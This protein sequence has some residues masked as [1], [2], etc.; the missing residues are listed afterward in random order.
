MSIRRIIFFFIFSIPGLTQ[1][2]SAQPFSQFR[3][4]I[5][6]SMF[7]P[8]LKDS[9]RLE[10]FFPREAELAP[11]I[12]YPVVFLFDRQNRSNYIYN[13]QTIDYLTHFGNMPAA[14][15]VGVEFPPLVRTKWT[16][17]ASAK[18][19]ADTLLTFL[20]GPFREQL[21]KECKLA[22]YN[23]LIGHSRTAM[24]A[25]YALPAF[26]GKI[27]AVIAASNSFFDFDTPSQQQLFE[28]YIEEKKL[29]PGRP[30]FF[31][32]SSGIQAY[33]DAHDS[34][35]S[36]LQ[37]YLSGRVFPA[38]FHWQ[39]YKENTSHITTPGLTTGRALN[40][41]F[42]PGLKALNTS[43]D[44]LNNQV[45]TDS[46]PWQD[47]FNAY[48]EASVSLGLELHPGLSFFNSIASGYLNDYN[49]RFK[50][51]KLKLTADVLRRGIEIYEGYP[52]FYSMM[53]SVE[54]ESGR[55]GN[56][57]A[58]LKKAREK[59]NAARYMTTE[60]KREEWEAIREVEKEISNRPVL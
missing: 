46:V 57:K 30:H 45:Q 21:E 14:V 60:L 59:L 27:N 49:D 38:D 13:L 44:I 15:L 8:G 56:A 40:D 11:A 53:A 34:S 47:Y 29:N 36:K 6:R 52:G 5:K 25:S 10:I 54:L 37:A 9:L 24:L 41:L 3:P 4:A 43:F 23:L 50:G 39:C 51:E 35:V 18:G 17:P 42:S 12:S 1:H 22:D 20:L 26:R 32:F 16:L 2:L 48:K 58:L 19:K 31:Y 7:V 55:P 33:G 28:N